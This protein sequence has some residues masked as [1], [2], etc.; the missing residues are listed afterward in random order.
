[1]KRMRDWFAAVGDAAGKSGK[2][3]MAIIA[4]VAMLGGVAGV[5]ATAMADQ[6]ASASDAQA[7]QSEEASSEAKA[8]AQATAEAS[9]LQP[10]SAEADSATDLGAP[11]HRKYIKYNNDGTYW[12]S[13]DVTGA[14]RAS[15]EEKHQPADVVLVM[16]SSGS[17]STQECLKSE[18]WGC[19]ERGD[20]RW[21]VATSAA[22]TLAQKLLTAD[23]AAL[24]ADQQVQM[25][26]IDFDTDSRIMTLGRGQWTTSAQAVSDSFKSMDA[27]YDNGGGTNWEA[28]L[29]NANSLNTARAGAKKYI[30]FV[31]D[32]EPTYRV[33]GGNGSN[34]DGNYNFNAAVA[35]ANRRN[36]A[37]LYAVSTGT[38]AN[39]KMQKFAQTINPAG[40]FFDG[41]DANKLAQAF[42]TI[43]EQIKTDSTYQ[44]VLI[45]DTL[46]GYAVSTD[47]NG[48]TGYLL[49]ASARDAD[50][51]DV[52]KTDP[53]ATKMHAVYNQQTQQLSLNFDEGTKLSPS[54]TYTVSIM[55]KPSDA[56]YQYFIENSGQYPNTGD[57]GTDA[58]GNNTSS[59]KPGFYSN[60]DNADGTTQA[61][62]YYKVVTNVNGQET[63]GEQQSSAYD[64]PVIQVNVPSITLTKGVDNTYAGKLGATPSDWKLSALKNSGTYGVEATNPSGETTTEGNVTK[65]SV[66]KTLVA[67]GTYT[68]SEVADTSTNYQ[69]FSGY[70]AGEWS[71]VDANGNNVSVSANNT[72]NLAQGVDLTCTVINTAKPG[73]IQWQK[74][75]ASKQNQLLSG[76]EWSLTGKTDTA[77]TKHV[78]DDGEND[79]ATD[80]AGTI[81]VSGLKW[82]D[83]SL[84]E[85]VAPKGYQLSDKTYDISVVPANDSSDD[86][87]FTVSAGNDGKITN[88]YIAVSQLP[89]TGGKSAR[90]WMVYGGGM[91]VLA[92]LAAA[93]YTIWRKRQLI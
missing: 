7:Q 78:V 14:S 44:D 13:L 8:K 26:V 30:V 58:E 69:Y 36:G 81:K 87:E 6:S 59:G 77:F 93:S 90:D 23:N 53:A 82:G 89:L 21:T 66:A 39:T 83:Y 3:I 63:V 74:V 70:T 65:Q 55:L 9:T 50:G 15:T 11:A 31:S 47:Q 60:A 57:Q 42:D 20:S 72:V 86:A 84:Q 10:E 79:A 49:S 85:T 92:L 56:A 35:E 28:A 12:L 2:R 24:P 16:D 68:L 80:S 48:G 27:S 29:R 76:S 38:E 19:A 54:V 91:G 1:M 40:T 4:A 52:S 18:W 51:N 37:T 43:I 17:M 73:A 88:T 25:S 5:S 64:R 67:P 33:N 34:D 32:G 41:T 61:N 62:V 45:K 71:C 75:N 22:K 46:S